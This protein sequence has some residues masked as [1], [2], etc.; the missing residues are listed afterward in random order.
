M[1]LG[2]EGIPQVTKITG[3]ACAYA[4]CGLVFWLAVVVKT[5]YS[6]IK[7]QPGSLAVRKLSPLRQI[8]SRQNGT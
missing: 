7:L 8:W 5:L 4:Q 2:G 6:G 3:E 1:A